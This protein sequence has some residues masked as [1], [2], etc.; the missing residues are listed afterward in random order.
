MGSLPVTEIRASHVQLALHYAQDVVAGRVV[1]CKWVKAAC[2]RQLDDLARERSDPDWPYT[3]DEDA[4]ER[5][6]VYI[7]L[8]RHVKSWFAQRTPGERIKLE[9]FQCFSLCCVFG[10]K[11]KVDGLRRFRSVYEEL[12]RKNAKSTKIAGVGLYMLTADGEFGA[13]VYGVATTREQARVVFEIAQAMGRMDGEYRARFGVEVLTHSLIVR[14]T[15][16]KMIPLAAEGSTLDGL[17]ASCVLDDELHA[18]KTRH[19]HDVM[20]SSMGSRSQ[21]LHWKITTA[22][23]NRAGICYDQRIYLTKILNAVLKRHDGLGYKVDGEATDDETFWGIIYT[24][25]EGDDPLDEAIWIKANPNYGISVDPEDMRRAAAMAKV[26]SAALNEF[27]TKRLNVW[28]NAD[29]AWMNMLQ[30]DACADRSLKEEDFLGE[31]CI[32]GL[33]AA[34]KKDLFAKVKLFRR[35]DDVYAFGRYYMPQA[36]LERRGWEQIAGWAR[37]GYIRTTEGEVLDIEAVREELI[38]SDGCRRRNVE[39]R[40]LLGNVAGDMARFEVKEIAF[41]PFQLT[42]FVGEMIEDGAPMV[43]MRAIP[44]NFSPA[45]KELDELVVGKRFHHNGDPVLAWA[46][47]NIVCHWDHKDNIYPNKE[48]VDQKID[49]AIA[50]IMAL[51]RIISTKQDDVYMTGNIIAL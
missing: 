1:A 28:V 20:D 38:G 9:P 41:D 18:H 32:I 17:N 14:E 48:S 42:Q 34:F 25:D 19:V 12:A 46:I 45:M 15:S 35:G 31:P 36:L 16:S 37:E 21:P 24:I 22:G 6:C 4:A 11:R 40:R 2:Q 23:F 43:E 49:P 3:F 10:W 8:L 29:S 47:S 13:E 33:D 30:W 39:D 50:L 44:K 7:S 27:L 5:V 26:Q 51:A